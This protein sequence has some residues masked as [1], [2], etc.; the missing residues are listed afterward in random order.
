MVSKE[1]IEDPMTFAMLNKIGS[2]RLSLLGALV[3][4]WEN[5]G[6][7]GLS[8]TDWIMNDD[9]VEVTKGLCNTNFDKLR[10]ARNDIGVIQQ[11]LSDTKEELLESK[12]DISRLLEVNR[13]IYEKYEQL[14]QRLPKTYTIDSVRSILYRF[15]KENPVAVAGGGG[16][17]FSGFVKISSVESLSAF[18]GTVRAR[19]LGVPS[20]I[21]VTFKVFIL[22]GKLVTL[23]EDYHGGVGYSFLWKKKAKTPGGVVGWSTQEAKKYDPRLG[24]DPAT[25][26]N[27]VDPETG[28][29]WVY[30]VIVDACESRKRSVSEIDLSAS[31]DLSSELS[32]ESSVAEKTKG[33]A[34]ASVSASG[35][36]SAS[37]CGDDEKEVFI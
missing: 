18:L 21:I 36:A 12:R 27:Y 35:S 32:S 13:D 31:S 28:K 5:M 30:P 23:S 34:A 19:E 3:Q 1:F 29:M 37:V 4:K 17:T 8:F 10:D 6:A 9:F 22:D 33:S 24:I 20:N 2:K 14:A 7:E 15:N 26:V 11:E 25:G 16:V